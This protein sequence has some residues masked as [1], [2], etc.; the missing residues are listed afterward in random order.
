[1]PRR[2]YETWVW[3]QGLLLALVIPLL[4]AAIV[5]PSWRWLVVAVVTFVLSFGISMGGAGL[6]PGLGEIFAVEGCFM[7]VELPRDSV[8]EVDIG[9]GWEKGG[10]AVVLFPYKKGIDQM[11]GDMAVSFFAPDEHGH[12]VCFAMFTYTAEK[13][14]ELAE[15]LR[16]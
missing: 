15:R 7:G 9:P 13:A 5:C 11:A 14:L 4:L 10:F 2:L 16:G 3:I 6:W 1:M 8:S 12:E